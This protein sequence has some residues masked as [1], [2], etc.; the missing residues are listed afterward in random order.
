[1][2]RT[3]AVVLTA[4]AIAAAPVLAMAAVPASVE[5]TAPA[6]TKSKPKSAKK[7]G[8]QKLLAGKHHKVNKLSSKVGKKIKQAKGKSKKPVPEKSASYFPGSA[9]QPG[10]Y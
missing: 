10:L 5:T 9:P 8:K 6:G 1:M 7:V 4:A 2:L 3:I